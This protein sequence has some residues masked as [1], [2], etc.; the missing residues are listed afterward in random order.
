[1]LKSDQIWVVVGVERKDHITA[2]ALA[3][4]GDL[5]EQSLSIK[6][7]ELNGKFISVSY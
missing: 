2:L 7:P 3:L 1:M 5:Q 6:Y 4:A